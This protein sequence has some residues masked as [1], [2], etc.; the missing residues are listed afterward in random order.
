MSVKRPGD[1]AM[2]DYSMA[3]QHQYVWLSRTALAYDI[4]N[5]ARLATSLVYG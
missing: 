4:R 1:G 3:L 2:A 5:E